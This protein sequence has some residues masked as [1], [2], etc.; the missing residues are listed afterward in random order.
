MKP[1]MINDLSPGVQLAASQMKASLRVSIRSRLTANPTTSALP[2][3]QLDA[4]AEDTAE[5]CTVHIVRA[6]AVTINISVT[7]K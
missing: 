7:E 3:E 4:I 2:A 6:A 1:I 5:A